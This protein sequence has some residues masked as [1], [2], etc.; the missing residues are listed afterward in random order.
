MFSSELSI[1]ALYGLW[2]AVIVV[3]QVLTAMGQVGF[4][5]LSRERSD[6]P[7]LTGIAGR[8]LR[9]LENSVVAMAL[10]APAVLIHAALGTLGQ[11]TLLPAQIFLAARVLFVPVYAAGIPL[12]RTAVWGVGFAATIWLYILAL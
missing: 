3:L 12:L 10:F 11:G 2:L 5:T 6:M 9:T 1:L 4:M 7:V 8:M